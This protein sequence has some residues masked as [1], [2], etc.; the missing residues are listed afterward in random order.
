MAVEPVHV[1][2]CRMLLSVSIGYYLKVDDMN[3]CSSDH[4]YTGKSD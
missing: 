1:T 3:H 4:M 2:I